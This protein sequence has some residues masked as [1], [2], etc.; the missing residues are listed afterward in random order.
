[1]EDDKIKS[2]FDSFNPEM[3]SDFRFIAELKNNLATVEAVRDEV[4]LVKSRSRKAVVIAAVAGFLAGFAFSFLLPLFQ[5]AVARW[6]V[7]FI[8]S[9]DLSIVSNYYFVVCWLLVA[10]VSIAVALNAY[11]VSLAVLRRRAARQ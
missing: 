9:K 3:S 1:M 10:A 6:I 7:S 2:L 4:N 8:D 11:D 5:N